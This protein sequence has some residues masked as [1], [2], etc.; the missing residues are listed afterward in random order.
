MGHVKM[1]GSDKKTRTCH[2]S[3]L[4]HSSRP[5]LSASGHGSVSAWD[6]G[7]VMLIRIQ[8]SDLWG[9]RPPSRNSRQG[10][11]SGQR[12]TAELRTGTP[13]WK[14]TE[15]SSSIAEKRETTLIEIG[16]I[17]DGPVVFVGDGD[18]I[19][20]GDGNMMRRWRVKDGREVRQPMDA[21]SLVRSIA[22]SRDGQWIVSG[23]KGGQVTVWNAE[24][25]EKV[26]EFTGHSGA[27]YAVDISPDT[28]SIATGSSDW[29]A[30]VWLRSTGERLLGPFKHGWSVGA[31]HFSPDG[32][33][34]AIATRDERF[35]GIYDSHD[36]RL[37]VDAPIQ[38][39]SSPNNTL[40]WASDSRQLFVLSHDASIHCLEVATGQVRST[41]AIHSNGNPRSMA[42]ASNG[43]FI[44]VASSSSVSFWDTATQK[45][46]GSLVH[47]PTRVRFIAISAKHDL[48]ISGGA[49][50]ILWKLAD[51]LPS[52]Y[53]DH[54]GVFSSNA[55]CRGYSPRAAACVRKSESSARWLKDVLKKP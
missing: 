11:G 29:T 30:S 22:V 51:I 41:R 44:A 7:R 53:L 28:T 12:E 32:R 37:L 6:D 3:L 8:E 19:V 34:M 20:G 13:E 24:S 47:H 38:A 17:N 35:V 48:V 45:Q 23:T 25:H 2:T 1:M 31:V 33:F 10:V 50:A 46:V 54:V 4:H 36:G 16:G 55:Q 5:C 21:G 42:L 40:A 49:K 52:S 27:V 9:D 43:A 15:G 26:I 14:E 39:S 18:Y